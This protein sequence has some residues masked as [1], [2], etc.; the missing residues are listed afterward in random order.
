[1][2]YVWIVIAFFIGTTAWAE[3]FYVRGA[4]GEYGTEDGSSYENAFDGWADIVWDTDG[5]DVNDAGEV[6]PGDT[7]YVCGRWLY[8]D[9][10][11]VGQLVV[12]ADGKEGLPIVIRG[13]LEGAEC[14]IIN[15]RELTTGGWTNNGDG[16]YSRNFAFNANDAWEGDPTLGNINQLIPAAHT[17]LMA[18]INDSVTVIPVRNAARFASSGTIIIGSEEITYTAVDLTSGANTIGTAEAPATRGAN[19][20]TPASHDAHS[21]ITAPT[22]DTTNA[23]I[24]IEGSFAKIG[25][26]IRYHPA[27]GVKT[28]YTNIPGPGFNV[29]GRDYIQ[30]RGFRIFGGAG[31]DGVIRINKT[32]SGSNCTNLLID[33]CELAMG[34]YTGIYSNGWSATNIEISNCVFHH[35]P[36]GIYTLMNGGPWNNWHV[37][38]NEAYSGG[39]L[40]NLFRASSADRHALGGQNIADSIWEDNYIH[41]WA[42]DGILVYSTSGSSIANNIV[43]RNRIVNLD[44]NDSANHHNGISPTGTNHASW[45]TLTAG[46]EVY[47]NVIIGCATGYGGDAA[48]DGSAFNL[49]GLLGGTGD[50][51]IKI[52][53]NAVY[54]CAIGAYW[55]NNSLE[56]GMAYELK[57]NLFLGNKYHIYQGNI[58]TGA[59]NTEIDYNS[60]YPDT[61]DGLNTFRWHNTN[62]TNFAD[63]QSD[64]SQDANS[65]IVD[66]EIAD[67]TPD[68]AEDFM[69]LSVDSPLVGAGVDVGLTTDYAGNDVPS[70]ADPDPDIG[71]YEFQ[72]PAEI[73]VSRQIATGEPP[74]NDY[75]YQE[76]LDGA[77]PLDLGSIQKKAIDDDADALLAT[78]RVENL[79][80]ETLNFTPD[81]FGNFVIPD[82]LGEWTVYQDLGFSIDGAP[83]YADFTIRLAPTLDAGTYSADI[84]INSDDA[85]EGTFNFSVLG[86]VLSGHTPGRFLLLFG[87]L[88]YYDDEEEGQ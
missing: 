12:G 36:T 78:F 47:Q 57:N 64:S 69:P 25:G 28:F 63:W 21:P 22:T 29:N 39:D 9:D 11:T 52:F 72:Y 77:G 8:I 59:D 48:G 30:V 37:H 54:D 43:R 31:N 88:F 83:N 23:V 80:D 5:D 14:T 49:K 85:D 55:Q 18:N 15:A 19:G 40:A 58:S 44:D 6:G 20:T 87:A 42:G 2:R 16:T 26:A 4:T 17:R 46:W 1:M 60:Y 81:D 67:D 53:N 68:A 84:V 66:P 74:P 41:D 73:Y 51:R 86:E 10:F 65:L 82:G 33:D 62:S 3:T 38:D 13:D 24:A 27:D 76:V 71:L 50:D 35:L 75:I 70:G 7:L 34:T 61:A 79:G 45:S 56:V 32:G